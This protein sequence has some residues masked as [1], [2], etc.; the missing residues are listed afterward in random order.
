MW[1][2]NEPC[3]IQEQCEF[4]GT[5]KCIN[6]CKKYY[7]SRQLY[8]ESNL[9]MKG[10]QEE[11]LI[12][13]QQDQET[14]EAC[15]DYKTNVL[16]RIKTGDGLFLWSPTKGNGKT[17][18][19]LKILR[20]YI[21]EE[22]KTYDFD[23]RIRAYYVNV[24]ELFDLLKN[25]FGKDGKIEQIEAG[26]YEADIVLFDDLGSERPTDWVR[27]KLY[28]YINHRYQNKKSMIFTSNLSLTEIGVQI[29]E[30]ISDRISEICQPLH[31]AGMSRRH[32]NRW[33][34]DTE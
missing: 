21:A 13:E 16:E 4:A 2:G 22:S 15:N 34:E 3:K 31:F 20:H 8:S 25:S 19:G 18:W 7:A 14:F 30:R 26:I 6:T 12:P 27:N 9:P 33:W 11:V 17:S 24:S 29:D 32:S 28:N 23:Y 10:V 5:D 1:W